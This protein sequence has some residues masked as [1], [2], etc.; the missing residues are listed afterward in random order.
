M[1]EFLLTSPNLRVPAS[2][3]IYSVNEG[4]ALHWGP[5]MTQCAL[6]QMHAPCFH[7]IARRK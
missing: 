7:S 6:L 2:G 1:G 4:N 3:S 5:A